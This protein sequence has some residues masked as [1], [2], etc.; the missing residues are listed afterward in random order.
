LILYVDGFNAKSS[1]CHSLTMV[2]FSILNLDP[3]ERYVFV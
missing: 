2:M 1:R 3:I